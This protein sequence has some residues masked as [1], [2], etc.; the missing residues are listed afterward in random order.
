MEILI[1]HYGKS[2]HAASKI[3]ELKII[4]NDTTITEDITNIHGGVNVSLIETL[5]QI[6]DEL[7]EQNTLINNSQ[8]KH[9]AFIK[10]S[11]N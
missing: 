7:E 2:T 8:K 5:R 4:S 3:I 11:R 1:K 6:A 10:T 9:S